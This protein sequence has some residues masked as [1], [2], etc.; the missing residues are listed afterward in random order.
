MLFKKLF[1]RVSLE[2]QAIMTGVRTPVEENN[3]EED[4][5]IFVRGYCFCAF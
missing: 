3:D 1:L 2:L 5:F 4:A